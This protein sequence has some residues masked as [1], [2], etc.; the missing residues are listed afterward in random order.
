MPK[1][2]PRVVTLDIETAPL[3]SYHWGLHDQNI[4]IEFVKEDWSILSVSWK[5]LDEDEVHFIHTGGRG[6]KKV[7]DDR[8][9]LKK[10]WPVLDEAD[11]VIGQN[12]KAFDI[13]RIN[14]RL[15]QHGHA[16]YSPVRIIDTMLIS[17][18]KFSFTSN[19]LAWTT[20]KLT[21]AKKSEHKKFPGFSL[22]AACLKDDA[23]AWAE[24]EAYNKLDVLSTEQL[25]LKFRPWIDNHPNV[26]VYVDA[27][28]PACP[29][30]GSDKIQRRG[31][32]FTQTGSYPRFQCTHCGGWSRGKSTLTSK[33]KRSRLLTW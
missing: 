13:P 26:N 27:E 15:I 21:E 17:K 2:G 22:W 30:C 32:A 28:D 10:I 31:N 3:E 12:I 20:K 14:A 4:G 9:V 11:L 16:P 6:A 24:M 8:G 7:R 19:K 5:W 33:I 29:K 25:Y 1:P 18:G 23:E